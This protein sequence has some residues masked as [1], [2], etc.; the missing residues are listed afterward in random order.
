VLDFGRNGLGHRG[1]QDD[2]YLRN[3]LR[4]EPQMTVMYDDPPPRPCGDSMRSSETGRHRLLVPLRARSNQL[5]A[6]GQFGPITHRTIK[7]GANP[8]AALFGVQHPLS[9]LERRLMADVL[10]VATR[11]VCHPV[12]LLIKVISGDRSVH[13]FRPKR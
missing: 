8:G 13:H 12:I 5:E 2:F 10:T 9:E 1:T 6:V 11:E 4:S 7:R 3:G